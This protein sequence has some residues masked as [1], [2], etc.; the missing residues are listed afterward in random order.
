MYVEG[1]GGVCVLCVCVCVRARARVHERE[2][3]RERV[4]HLCDKPSKNHSF[5]PFS[6]SFS[7]S[8]TLMMIG[9][10]SFDISRTII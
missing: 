9:L 6:S 10:A 4:G 2:S 3:E 7:L 5:I 8:C 1:G